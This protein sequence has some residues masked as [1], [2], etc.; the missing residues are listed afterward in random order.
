MTTDPRATI[1]AAIPQTLHGELWSIVRR[2]IRER[3]G[4]D[5]A[6][7]RADAEA[8]AVVDRLLAH[9]GSAGWRLVR[10]EDHDRLRSLAAQTCAPFGY[11]LGCDRCA[12]ACVCPDRD[13]EDRWLFGEVRP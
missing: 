12:P 10:A 9:L 5:A 11:C 13:A 3:D 2:A 8:V 1:A 7:A 6:V 4:S